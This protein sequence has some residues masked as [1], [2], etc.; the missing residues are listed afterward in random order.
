MTSQATRTVRKISRDATV[1]ELRPRQSAALRIADQPGS[2]GVNET[3][4][5]RGA[6][7]NYREREYLTEPEVELIYQAAKRY[8]RYGAR[9]A[10]MVWVAY[11]HGLRVGELVGLTWGQID[12]AASAIHVKRLKNGRNTASPMDEREIR[13]LKALQKTQ[14]GRYVWVNERG[15]I[16]TTTGFRKTLARLSAG[17]LPQL[18]PVHPHMLRH[19]TGYALA[20]RG[21][22]L[23]M[24]RDLLGHRDI[25]NT[26][27][28]AELAPHRLMDAWEGK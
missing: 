6:N 26:T 24:V 22:D 1:V 4:L 10:L 8:G 19:A 20:N 13:G 21:T 28:Y 5:R 7:A 25:R 12:F 9:D 18:G 2:N 11:R 16:C 23:L 15:A 3:V 17:V 14:Q 27:I